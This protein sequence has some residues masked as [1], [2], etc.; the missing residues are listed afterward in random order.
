MDLKDVKPNAH[1]DSLETYF[2]YIEDLIKIKKGENTTYGRKY[3]ILPI[4]EDYFEIDANTRTITVPE[5][6]RKNGLGVMGDNTAETIYFKINRYFDAMDLNTADIYIQWENSNGDKGISKEWVRDIDTFD[7]FMV[8]GWVLGN[9]IT[10]SSGTI[11]F[12]IRFIKT[13]Q[14]QTPDEKIVTYSFSTLNAHALINP[15]L[16]FDVNTLAYD[17]TLNNILANN[18]QNTNT[19]TDSDISVFKYIHDFDELIGGVPIEGTNIISTDLNEDGQLQLL[20]SAYANIGTL[21]YYLYKQIGNEIDYRNVDKTTKTAMTI[22]YEKTKDTAV[23][24]NKKYYTDTN[25]TLATGLQVGQVINPND[26]YEAYGSYILSVDSKLT[27]DKNNIKEPLPLTGTYYGAA[28]ATT[29]DESQSSPLISNFKVV[30]LLPTPAVIKTPLENFGIENTTT[31]TPEIEVVTKNV[32]TYKWFK[33][34]YNSEEFVEIEGKTEATCKTNGEGI[35]KLQVTTTRNTDSIVCENEPIFYVTERPNADQITITSGGGDYVISTDLQLPVTASYTPSNQL[36]GTTYGLTYQWEKQT[37]PANVEE[38]TEA[39]YEVIP[40]AIE[41]RFTPAEIGIYRCV[42]TAT[43]N[44]LSAS[45][46][47]REYKVNN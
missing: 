25:G 14:G 45:K 17:D 47:T 24:S 33:K 5:V 12:S 19:K 26:Y 3:S 22:T 1:I 13:K 6:F 11:K 18:F 29:P 4:Q 21:S 27:I 31:I 44:E 40:N 34:V 16:D 2:T 38:G 36:P 28:V 37:K 42:V 30:L 39:E 41:S 32:P 8:F 10:K 9:N 35:Y 7:D 15:A 23:Q 20:I 46:N 43:Y